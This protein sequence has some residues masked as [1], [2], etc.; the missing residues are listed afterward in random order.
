MP[1]S[2]GACIE[3]TVRTFVMRPPG[4]AASADSWR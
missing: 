1:L 3:R 4:P 2:G